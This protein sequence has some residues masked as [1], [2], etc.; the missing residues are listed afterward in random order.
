MGHRYIGSKTEIIPYIIDNIRTLVPDGS[1][2]IDLMAGTGTVS[3]ELRKN[4]Y[5]VTA[6]DLMTYSFHHCRVALLFTEDPKF[7]FAKKI[8]ENVYKNNNSLLPKTPYQKVIDY[9]NFLDPNPGYFFREFCKDGKPKNNNEPRNYFLPENAAKIDS[10]RYEIKRLYEEHLINDLEHSLLIHD[11]IM[12]TNDIANIAGTYGHYLSTL[13]GRAKTQICLQTT[14]IMIR[15]DNGRHKVFQ[16]YAE[17]LAPILSGN[18]CYIDPPYM[19]RQYAANYHILETIARED[20]PDAIGKSGLRP[21]R[22]QYSDFCT[23][24]KVEK[25][26]KEIIT[27]I[28]C[29]KFL[30]SYSDEGLITTNKLYEFLKYFGHV[31]IIEFK[32]KRFKSRPENSRKKVSEY[33]F[34]LNKN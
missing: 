21:W 19:K 11:L 4:G 12:A 30:I 10:I 15:K 6:C 7:S 3:S 23:K 28:Q 9:L 29:D 32:H 8:P 5:S 26:F 34:Y 20:T 33:L 18:L 2:I 22:D 17:Q 1:H 24:T 13:Q 25:A 31:S 14:P 27:R 16:G